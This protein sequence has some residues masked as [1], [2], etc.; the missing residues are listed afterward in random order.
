M[1][2]HRD[3][4]CEILS[5]HKSNSSSSSN[6]K[7]LISEQVQRSVIRKLVI[8]IIL[9]VMFMCLELVGGFLA[10]SLAIICDGFHLLS[11]LGGFVI[12]LISTY[13]ST[14][15]AT[16][17]MNFGFRRIEI[18]G[19]F[20]SVIF[21]WILT[22]SLL[23]MAVNRIILNDFEIDSRQVTWKNWGD[24]KFIPIKSCFWQNHD[25]DGNDWRPGECDHGVCSLM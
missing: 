18:L 22:G 1:S 12:S 2:M 16:K 17:K 8:I 6:E 9:C 20:S 19:A 15:R 23:Y 11:D 14:R 3:S 13:L 25:S 7:T 10:N 24:S 5:S 21:I 4:S